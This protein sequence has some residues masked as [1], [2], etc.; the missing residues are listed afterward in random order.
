MANSAYFFPKRDDFDVYNLVGTPM[1]VFD[2][3]NHCMWWGN[4]AALEF[5]G[6]DT[7]E[8]F[9]AR[10]YSDDSPTVRTRIRQMVAPMEYGDVT[11]DSWT[12]YPDGV[13]TAVDTRFTYIQIGEDKRDA[14]INE[15]IP[16][17]EL[18]LE[19]NDQRLIEAVR[20]SS[21][22]IQYFD[23]DGSLR[24]ANPTAI[25]VF[26]NQIDQN[27]FKFSDC[28]AREE[29]ADDMFAKCIQDGIL[30]GEYEVK[31]KLGSRWHRIDLKHVP[32]PAD[33][34]RC[35]LVLQEDV[36]SIK[37]AETAAAMSERLL[38]DAIESLSVG[39][40]M[41]DADRRIVLVNEKYREM[42][43]RIGGE[44]KIGMLFEELL[45]ASTRTKIVLGQDGREDEWVQQRMDRLGECADGMDVEMAGGF[46]L[47][48]YESHT[49][50]G[51]IAGSR[52]DIT[53]LK[54]AQ[55]EA[56]EANRAKT[57]FLSSMSHELR[58]PLN[59]VMGFAQMLEYDHDNPLNDRQRYAVDMIM[60]S[61]DFLL[62][63]I[64][65]VLDL[66]QIEMGK[67]RMQITDIDPIAAVNDSISATHAWGDVR[68]IKMIKM[69]D[70]IQ[71]PRIAADEVRL[72]QVLLNLLSNAV[73]YNDD[74]G[75]VTVDASVEDSRKVRISVTDTG[76]GIAAEDHDK[77]FLPFDRLGREAQNIEGTGVGLTITKSLVEYMKGEIG[78]T[79]TVGKGSTFWIDFPVWDESAVDETFTLKH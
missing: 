59:S 23:L 68:G 71:L 2:I 6:S 41:L 47:R 45:R 44:V 25:D 54:R 69:P 57:E 27:A 78:F 61:S 13:P 43:R 36:T 15:A 14:I 22:M 76:A 70:D 55:K 26:G 56:V 30:S 73:K 35:I 24:F 28:L 39:F 3:P 5:W 58:T 64:K 10:D 18:A 66:S 11:S 72:K 75:T 19:E 63:L 65:E 50:S 53:E 32:D 1:W 74:G 17:R 8:D 48:V 46:W 12:L 60:K 52:M 7:L 20:H 9:I 34:D 16:T 40:I 79:S 38:S 49:S 29:I 4:K 67:F 62:E 37:H 51:G 31:T 42:H 21:T 77:V 33:G